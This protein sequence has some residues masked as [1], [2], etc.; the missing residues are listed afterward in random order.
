MAQ[1]L[2]VTVED[3]G[4]S[5]VMVQATADTTQLRQSEIAAFRQ[6]LLRHRPVGVTDVVAGLESLLVQFDPLLT[7]SEHI[8]YACGLMAQL[9]AGGTD[10]GSDRLFHLPVVFDDSTGPDLRDVATELGMPCAQLLRALTSTDLSIVLLAAA[11]APMMTGVTLPAP[12]RRQAEP[13]TDVPPGSI[14]LAG[15]N[16]IIQPFNGPTGWR[17]VGRTPMSIVDITRDPPVSFEPGDRIRL[18]PVSPEEA[19]RLSGLFL[20]DTH[21]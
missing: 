5:A 4:D 7:R 16:A 8:A 2:A 10:S 15:A 1:Q 11:M 20:E 18:L 17:V 3:Y 12:I 21:G 6:A 14:M 9:P 13:R 19:A